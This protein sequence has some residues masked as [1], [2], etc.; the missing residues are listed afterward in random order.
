[1]TNQR[2]K[3]IANGCLLLGLLAIAQG[4]VAG[5]V[6]DAVSGNALNGVTVTV[7]N[8]LCTNSNQ[9]PCSSAQRVQTTRTITGHLNGTYDGVFVFDYDGNVN[10]TANKQTLA[11]DI[12]GGEEAIALEF[13]KRGYQTVTVWHRPNP[14]AV[15]EGDKSY[16]ATVTPTVYLC[17]INAVDSDADGLC[18]SAELKLETDKSN[19]DTDGDSIGDLAEAYGAEHMDL[20]YYGANARRKD[21]FVEIDYYAGLRPNTNALERVRKAFL[22]APLENHD[23]STGIHYHAVVD[24]QIA[25][26][27]E[28]E[29]G[30]FD[31]ETSFDPIK[32]EYHPE[33]RRPFFHYALVVKELRPSAEGDKPGDSGVSRGMPGHDYIVSLGRAG[34]P[35]GTELQQAGTHMHELGHN[36]G[37][38]HGGNDNTDHKVNYLSVMNRS[39]QMHGL[40]KNG[41]PG[42]LDFSRYPIKAITESR[43]NE[44]A[45]FTAVNPNH[46]DNLLA[47]AVKINGVFR[48]NAGENL[49]F[50]GDRIIETSVAVDLNGN[51]QTVDTIPESINDWNSLDFGGS[52]FG[53]GA[54]GVARESSV[55][56]ARAFMVSEQAPMIGCMAPSG[57]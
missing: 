24:Q 26:D 8:G 2:W 52:A 39:Y 11:A 10:G 23:R 9:S 33:R 13:T 1:M 20:I 46:E 56:G 42:E 3:A 19:P 22:G 5:A 41:T 7:T 36:L 30:F 32:N 47:Y 54:I 53:G 31:W 57:L 55:A 50:N 6:K 14:S 49:D 15:T 45:A 44:V 38:L 17:P 18:D 37:L 34:T 21:I 51:R 29:Y 48:Q 16:L 4:C 35:G 12:E 28:A 43:L 27:D 25:S 40:T